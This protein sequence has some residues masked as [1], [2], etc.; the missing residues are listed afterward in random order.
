MRRS[1]ARATGSIGR[2][3]AGEPWTHLPA[4]A[5]PTDDWGRTGIAVTADGRRVYAMID[6]GKK[7][8]LY[9][10]D[11]GGDTWTLANSDARLTSRAWYFSSIAVDPSNADVLYMPNV[12]LYR[13]EDGGKTISDRARRAR[14]RRLSPG[15]GRSEELDSHRARRRSGRER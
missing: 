3:T 15:V 10:S 5:C 13:T 1:K 8:G 14:R 7:S 6:D 4:T 12:A 2:K 9:R 11:D